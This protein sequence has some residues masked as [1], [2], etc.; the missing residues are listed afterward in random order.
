MTNVALDLDADERNDG[1]RTRMQTTVRKQNEQDLVT[2][3]NGDGQ[4]KGKETSVNFWLQ[5][6]NTRERGTRVEG[7][8]DILSLRRSRDIFLEIPHSHVHFEAWGYT[9]KFETLDTSLVVFNL[10]PW[11]YQKTCKTGTQITPVTGH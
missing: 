7:E 3:G 6:Q 8:M 1:R 11:K 4:G 10:Q 2:A 9:C 5:Q